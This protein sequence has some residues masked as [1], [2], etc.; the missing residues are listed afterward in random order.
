MSAARRIARVL[1][2]GRRGVVRFGSVRAFLAVATAFVALTAAD[3]HAKKVIVLGF[4]GLDPDRVREMVDEGRLPNIAKMAKTGTL[5][6]LGTSI[7]PQSPVAWSN[8]ITGMDSGGHGIFDFLHRH[9]ETMIPYLSTS[10][11]K[12][13]G[14]SFD[15]GK[16]RI[17][18]GGGYHLLRHGTPFWETLEDNGVKTMIIRMPANFPVTEKA[19][20]ELSGMRTPDVRGTYGSFSYYTSDRKEKAKL[21]NVGGGTVYA[22]RV[23]NHRV[24]GTLEGPPDPFLI[25]PKRGSAPRASADFTVEVDPDRPAALIRVGEEEVLLEQGDWSDWVPIDLSMSLMQ[26]IP[27]IARFYLK[28]VRPQFRLY[29]TPLNFD[30]E[31]PAIPMEYP[32]GFAKEIAEGTGRFYSQGFPE[33]TK[34]L[35]EHVLTLAEFIEQ[36]AIAG[37]EILDEYPWFLDKFDREFGDDDAMLF[38]YAGN[39]DQMSHMLYRCM[40]PTHPGYDPAVHAQYAH[41][42]PDIIEK[43]DKV[44]GLTLDRYGDEATVIIMSDHGFGSWKRAMHLNSWLAQEG[45]LAL[46]DPDIRKDP[47]LFLNVDWTRTRVY[48]LGLNGLYVNE[49]GRERNGI[50]APQDKQGLLEEMAHKLVKVV[51]PET[52]KHAVSKAYLSNVSYHDR[53]YLDVGPDAIVGYAFEYRGSNQSAMGEIPKEIF[54]DNL[55]EWTGDHCMDHVT[56]PGT[57]ATNK[58][59]A[60][61]APNLQSLAA[62]ILAE[63][64]VGVDFPGAVEDLKAVGYIGA[65]ETK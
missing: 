25:P 37:N 49:R 39:H 47:G 11:P 40:D 21:G 45:Y 17:A 20:F 36:G 12:D 10:E 23:R 6:D 55:D 42:I 19:S 9:P 26:K 60:K 31:N 50:V 1:G 3:A 35:D 54:T 18:L 58:P 13:A 15:V 56:V 22:V 61:A 4:D 64:G 32:K 8:F 2:N 7:P 27:V 5:Q 24:E 29:V 57:L 41:V 63:F 16:Y 52:G 51:D 48:G 62:A 53:G 30:P 65:P 38:Y 46:K 59:L 28:E 14:R 43:M 34:A 44:V 33:D